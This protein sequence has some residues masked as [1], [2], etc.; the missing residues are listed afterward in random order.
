MT[1]NV[2]TPP[3]ASAPMVLPRAW[4][5]NQRSSADPPPVGVGPAGW[6]V[7]ADI[8][9]LD[10]RVAA[11]GSMMPARPARGKGRRAGSPTARQGEEE[12][13]LAAARGTGVKRL[14]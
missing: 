13:R 6:R 9:L 5:W 12:G 10:G 3:R 4:I 8:C 2:V 14:A 1:T 7:S 11:G